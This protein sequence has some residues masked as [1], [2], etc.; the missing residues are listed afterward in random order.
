MKI[1][2]YSDNQ[3][4]EN[5]NGTKWHQIPYRLPRQFILQKILP[6]YDNVE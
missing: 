5:E 6:K 3:P 4:R 1:C 2:V